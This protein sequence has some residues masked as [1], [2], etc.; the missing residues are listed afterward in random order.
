MALT[1]EW[2]RRLRAWRTEV[3]AH[4]YQPLGPVALAGFT[5][6]ERMDVDAARRHSFSPM[7]PGTRWGA[8][9]EYGWFRGSVSVPKEAAGRRLVLR[10][11]AGGEGLLYVNGKAFAA[12]DREHDTITLSRTAS[13]GARFELLAEVYA[14]HGPLVASTGP[15]A[16]G[17]LSVPEPPPRQAVVGESSFGIWEE[18]VYQLM[19]DVETL[20][21]L[22]S[23]LDV[24]QLRVAE[25]D[26]GLRD[27]T[28]IVDFELPKE[29]M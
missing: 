17:R 9:W 10:L 11:D 3:R 4:L 27:F 25:I 29:E 16:P 19:M 2:N 22:R 5:T 7:P 12:R 23:T 6:L 24:N 20:F 26:A 28:T 15:V 14:G 8:K 21:G 18:D 13:T 1:N